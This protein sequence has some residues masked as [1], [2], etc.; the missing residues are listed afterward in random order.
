MLTFAQHGRPLV[1][2]VFRDASVEEMN[3][4][5]DDAGLDVIQLHG[6]EGF[7]ICSR[8][9]RPCVRVMHV[10]PGTTAADILSQMRPGLAAAVLLDTAVK[11]AAGGGTGTTFDW[12]LAQAVAKEVPLLVAG[13]LTP[14]NVHEAV[15]CV[16]AGCLGVDVSSGTETDGRKDPAKL[17]AFVANAKA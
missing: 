12:A 14:V 2:G 15:R 8:L 4:V 13:G 5:A 16:G 3:Q 10:S 9:R 17:A 11:G 6:S 1:V 7:E